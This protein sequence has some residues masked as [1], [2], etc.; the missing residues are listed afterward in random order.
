[1]LIIVQK[2]AIGTCFSFL[3][4]NRYSKLNIFR[5]GSVGE[6]GKILMWDFSVTSLHKP[7]LSTM[8]RKPKPATDT[9]IEKNGSN[10]NVHPVL[11]KKEVAILEPF[12]VCT[13]IAKMLNFYL[14]NMYYVYVFF[15]SLLIYMHIL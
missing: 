4:L 13:K 12:M 6:D 11:S 10:P 15:K 7:K 2:E 1:M 14:S 8:P 3:F 5:F 9:N